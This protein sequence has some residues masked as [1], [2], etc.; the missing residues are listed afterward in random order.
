MRKCLRKQA[1]GSRTISMKK[2]SAG[3]ALATSLALVGIAAFAT[4]AA[5]DPAPVSTDDLF[6]VIEAVESMD[7]A[8]ARAAMLEPDEN[9]LTLISEAIPFN[10]VGSDLSSALV[11]PD[12]TL[13]DVVV[14]LTDS[15]TANLALSGTDDE[16]L[17]ASA[18]IHS[19]DEVSDGIEFE[20]EPGWNISAGEGQSLVLQDDDGSH[21]VWL[22]AGDA[23]DA[24]GG[25]VP[26]RLEI[27]EGGFT[28]IL[29][30]PDDAAFPITAPVA[31]SSPDLSGINEVAWCILHRMAVA[32]VEAQHMANVATDAARGTFP[33]NTLHNG[34]GDAFRHCYWNARMVRNFWITTAQAELIATRH[35]DRATHQPRN[36]RTMDLRNNALG[37]GIGGRVASNAA[38]F[39]TCRNDANGGRLW[40][41]RNG[42][43]VQAAS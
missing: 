32:C 28:V 1:E 18:V 16:T 31:L 35:E 11:V 37:R 9:G 17:V 27:R 20:L 40:I 8:Q 42:A 5:A 24:E 14:T 38:A 6:E 36:E 25:I 15:G 19:P 4:P 43:L 30:V 12:D 23:I 3:S 39:T 7:A 41:L 21:E 29:D 26:A 33:A 13:G 34:R 22:S 2:W 10:M